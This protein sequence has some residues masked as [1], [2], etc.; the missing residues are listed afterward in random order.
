MDC[1]HSKQ[2]TMLF[3]TTLIASIAL[4]HPAHDQ[5]AA[6]NQ[7]P[8]CKTTSIIDQKFSSGC[9]D[10]K[11]LDAGLCYN[12][13]PEGYKGV[14]PVCWKGIKSHPRGVGT[15]RVS[16][17]DCPEHYKAILAGPEQTPICTQ[18]PSFFHC[19]Q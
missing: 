12:P 7:L 2:K 17:M 11:Q 4:A 3:S 10:G 5:P 13:C 18:D 8:K 1:R 9:P 6:T 19:E 16:K 15:G 14:G